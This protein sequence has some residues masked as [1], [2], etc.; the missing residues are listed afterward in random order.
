MRKQFA[1][2]TTDI[3]NSDKRTALLLGDIG[4]FAFRELKDRVYNIGICEQSM[5][6][7]ASGM[8][9]EGM[10]PIVHSIAP[11]ITERNYEQLKLNFGYQ[12]VGGNFVSVG[13]S[14]DYSS[15]GSTHHC[16]ADVNILK[17]IPN[18]EI[19]VPGTAQE[20]DTLF[21][22][23]YTNGKPT[24]YRLSEHSNIENVDVTFGKANVLKV[25]RDATV[26]VVGNMLSEVMEACEDKDVTILYY[27]TIAPFDFA[28]LQKFSYSHKILLCEPYYEGGLL[29][30]IIKHLH[31]C[32]QIECVGIPHKFLNSKEEYNIRNRLEK[33]IDD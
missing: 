30:D 29:Y 11:F 32:V 10:I 21:R 25:G 2:T 16:P 22:Q 18:M 15:L 20:F 6:S 3:L 13:S 31:G 4:V 14:C 28:T 17:Q 7:L 8:A 12:N 33:L 1:K 19:V 9:L 5:T 27:T 23:S 26:I 24:Y